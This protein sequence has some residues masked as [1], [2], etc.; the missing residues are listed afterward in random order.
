MIY[1][2]IFLFVILYVFN[3]KQRGHFREHS[4]GFM[5]LFGLYT[6]LY[7]LLRDDFNAWSLPQCPWLL[8]L[9]EKTT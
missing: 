6:T 8:G 2:S 4:H 9:E 5:Q 7:L 3:V 1:I